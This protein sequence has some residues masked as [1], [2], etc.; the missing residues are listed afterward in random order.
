MAETISN[1]TFRTRY[2]ATGTQQAINGLK[3]VDASLRGLSGIARGID[4]LG[5]LPGRLGAQLSS[6][7]SALSGLSEFMGRSLPS[8]VATSGGALE[9]LAAAGI[10]LNSDVMA[11]N[12]QLAAT[13]E[14]LKVVTGA[15]GISGAALAGIGV[16]AGAAA[17][18]FVGLKAAWQLGTEAEGVVQAEARLVAFA[19][20]ASAAA[21]VIRQMQAAADGSMTSL[22]AMTYGSRLLSMGLAD[23]AEQAAKL[24]RGALMLGPATWTAEQKIYSLTMM[25]SNQSIRRLDEFGLSIDKIKGK[26]QELI[27]AGMD[28]Q[29]AF[30]NA[31]LEAM[32]E[33]VQLVEAAGGEAATGI[34]KLTTAWANLRIE[35]GKKFEAP[36]SDIQ[37]GLAGILNSLTADIQ[38]G[39]A[40]ATTQ[41]VGLYAKLEAL[42]AE[43][44]NVAANGPQYTTTPSGFVVSTGDADDYAAAIA[45]LEA[46]IAALT[47]AAADMAEKLRAAGIASAEAASGAGAISEAL[48]NLRTKDEAAKVNAVAMAIFRGEITLAEAA[49]LDLNAAYDVVLRKNWTNVTRSNFLEERYASQTAAAAAPGYEQGRGWAGMR[50]Q[51]EQK[52]EREKE[53]EAEA[54]KERL[55]NLKLTQTAAEKAADAVADKFLKLAQTITTAIEDAQQKARGLFDLG[56]GGGGGIVTEPGKGGP[57]EAL[58][59]ITDVAATLAGRAP[60]A[61]TAKWQ[62]MYG[63]MDYTGAATA[64]QQGNLLAPGVFENID[65]QLLGQQALQQQ[66]ASKISTYAGQAVAGLMSAGKPLTAE[67]I[68]GMIDQLAAAD[69]EGIVPS[70]DNIK[71]ALAN[72]DSLRATEV[73]TVVT[74]LDGLPS[75][76]AAALR[77]PVTPPP[78]PGSASGA[79]P[80]APISGK[81]AGG[82]ASAPGGIALVGERGPE[83]IQLPRS[84]RVYTAQETQRLL[85]GGSGQ[86]AD[87]LFTGLVR[88][89]GAKARDMDGM[90]QAAAEM[91][92]QVATG[93]ALQ[94]MIKAM[95]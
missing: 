44:A 27:E 76:I 31:V 41:L 62:A 46:R 16:A 24:T 75:A 35:V 48:D 50:W 47:P 82:T 37:T 94:T 52:A 93:R 72:T 71:T 66:E 10:R 18:A 58:Y 81:F 26:Q 61:D 79:Q 67:N 78:P 68:K 13:G 73:S 65:W 91:V 51:A 7:R 11:L 12:P 28:K 64:F 15:A 56:G 17:A 80:P 43:Q 70:L 45:A 9:Q 88:A 55:K 49:M 77:A 23:S 2:D 60:G 14:G 4:L 19:G 92:V 53:A 33:K 25:L 30:T 34:D 90:A 20:S 84:S 63:G 8:A 22:A 74:A 59:R 69:K 83:L 3:Q 86:G 39:S 29:L 6:V 95:R 40:D 5:I 42:K 54:E 57:F 32:A 89:I 85:S 21:N 38:A 1:I 87:E 36:V